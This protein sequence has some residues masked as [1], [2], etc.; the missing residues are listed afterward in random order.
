M[1]FPE[2]PLKVAI[3]EAV[4][5][6]KKFSTGDSSRFVNGVLDTIAKQFSNSS[7]R[8]QSDAQ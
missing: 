4:D 3:N 8:N 5:I 1:H 2:I 6:A 7:Q